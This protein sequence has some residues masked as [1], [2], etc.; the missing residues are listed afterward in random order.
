V[1]FLGVIA[2]FV[3]GLA[4]IIFHFLWFKKFTKDPRNK[5]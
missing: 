5:Q 2:S 3:T 4:I 1:I